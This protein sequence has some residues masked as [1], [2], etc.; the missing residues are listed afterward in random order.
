MWVADAVAP[1]Q[2]SLTRSR[3][4]RLTLAIAA[5]AGIESF[6]WLV[7]VGGVD[8]ATAAAVLRSTCSALLE[9]ELHG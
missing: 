2:D 6:A 5:A 4:E 1:L 8:R 7:D 3:F 9:H